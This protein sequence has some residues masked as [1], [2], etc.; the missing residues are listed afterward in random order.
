MA[1]EVGLQ[2]YQIR[3]PF[4][5]FSRGIQIKS[6]ARPHARRHLPLPAF[7]LPRHSFAEVLKHGR[8]IDTVHRLG[9]VHPQRGPPARD[10]V[11]MNEMLLQLTVKLY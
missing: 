4:F 2:S 7:G 9:P 8:G 10:A 1:E 6:K 3:V 5:S 11:K